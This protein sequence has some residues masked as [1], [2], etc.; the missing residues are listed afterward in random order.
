MLED[1]WYITQI[2]HRDENG[3]KVL[4]YVGHHT[5]DYFRYYWKKDLRFKW[6][7]CSRVFTIGRLR[8]KNTNGYDGAVRTL[9]HMRGYSNVI[10]ESQR[11]LPISELFRKNWLTS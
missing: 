3:D 10:A 4:G 6:R 1:G 8:I 5:D 7:R 11:V 9:L 2:I